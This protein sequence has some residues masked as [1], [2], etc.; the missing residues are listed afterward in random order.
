MQIIGEYISQNIIYPQNYLFICTVEL[1]YGTFL[2]IRNWFSFFSKKCIYLVGRQQAG[3]G[4][5]AMD[6]VIEQIT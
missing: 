2:A 4:C 1:V 3:N 5:H 6:I